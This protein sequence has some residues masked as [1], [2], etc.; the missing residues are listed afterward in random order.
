[1]PLFSCPSAAAGAGKACLLTSLSA[2]PGGACL[3]R[4]ARP[5]VPRLR[6]GRVLPLMCRGRH[7]SSGPC[8]P[9]SAVLPL[10]AFSLPCRPCNRCPFPGRPGPAGPASLAPLVLPFLGSVSDGSSLSCAEGGTNRQ[11]PA[12]HRPP[13]CLCLPAHVLIGRGR[14]GLPPSLRSSSR[15]SAPPRKGPPSHVP[16]AAQ[17]V[18]PQPSTGRH[19]IREQS[20]L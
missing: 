19:Y 4:S 20:I 9:P 13:S 14:R 12:V 7:K 8:R 1:V 16:R 2:G 11:A 3:P 17:V 5:P 6:L 15:S 18:R 10:P